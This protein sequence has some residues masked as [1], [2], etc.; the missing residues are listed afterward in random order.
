MTSRRR[1]RG[2]DPGAR[3]PGSA[4]CLLV[5]GG[6]H[7]YAVFLD[8]VYEATA[9]EFVSSPSLSDFYEVRFVDMGPRP[10]RPGSG[11]LAIAA[12]A[13]GFTTRLG[14]VAKNFSALIIFDQSADSVAELLR[15][16]QANSVLSDL[17]VR[18]QGMAS[19][20]DRKL[21]NRQAGTEPR[22]AIAPHGRRTVPEFVTEITAF[23]ENL[24]DHFGSGVETGVPAQTVNEIGAREQPKLRSVVAAAAWANEDAEL[25]ARRAELRRL[26][27]IRK[28][29]ELSKETELRREAEAR[30]E[31]GKK[32]AE[33]RAADAREAA[34]IAA[35][36]GAKDV[37]TVRES[38]D[39]PDA[40]AIEEVPA[41]IK[42]P[43]AALDAGDGPPAEETGP[44]APES[45]AASR[46]SPL[47]S[48]AGFV[49]RVRGLTTPKQAR[50][51]NDPGAKLL[52]DSAES[53]RAGDEQGLHAY[54][55]ALR[56]YADRGISDGQRQHYLEIVRD[57]GLLSTRLP[58]VPLAEAFCESV[59]GLL[60]TMPLNYRAYC[61]VEDLALTWTS[62]SLLPYPLLE[63]IGRSRSE[64]VKP[65][66]IA[67]FQLGTDR[68]YAWLRSGQVSARQLILA[69]DDHGIR[70]SHADMM[71]EAILLLLH[72]TRSEHDRQAA[73]AALYENG[74]LATAIRTRYPSSVSDQVRVL[75]A[76]L[77]AV[78]PRGLDRRGVAAVL[79]AD[80]PS[81]ALA[82]AVLGELADPADS[83]WAVEFFAEQLERWAAD[84]ARKAQ[85]LKLLRSNAYELARPS[86][87]PEHSGR[88]Q[89]E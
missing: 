84:P 52:L 29:A 81:A 3:A 86:S 55:A 68:L 33:R 53:L 22:I 58:V 78:Y 60:F 39:L 44:E 27:E 18:L 56:I 57:G 89:G 66:I 12:L 72:R 19:Y 64:D 73:V 69:A 17:A 54:L 8:A 5:I 71:Y 24:L 30:R 46:F 9:Q 38:V 50:L 21:A 23:A 51:D 70:P 85:L 16:C 47:A 49:S 42:S 61:E 35:R 36:Q 28:E 43:A 32:I 13:L 67:N 10:A 76:I 25:N 4:G 6:Y 20:E 37:D 31:A 34:V 80:T 88:P 75:R 41:A 7:E 48:A 15:E 14:D 40:D 2:T 79:T 59:L 62:G 74:Y 1:S 65:G 77:G 26:A 82:I 45:G 87:A 63:V 11:S 83:T